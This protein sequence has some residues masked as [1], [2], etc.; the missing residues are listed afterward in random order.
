MWK[1]PKS[2]LFTYMYNFT[3]EYTLEPPFSLLAASL[4]RVRV[5]SKRQSRETGFSSRKQH[6]TS[7][8]PNTKHETPTRG[9]ARKLPPLRGHHRYQE[10]CPLNK[11]VHL[12]AFCRPGPGE[13]R[14]LQC[15]AGPE[16]IRL[17][18]EFTL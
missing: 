6:E 17:R 10:K 9:A 12:I 13:D 11:G 18:K 1:R 16:G 15:K 14:Q 8:K 3:I 5:A 7:A 2:L 4:V